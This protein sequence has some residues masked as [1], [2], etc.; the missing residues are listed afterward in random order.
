MF[1]N[2]RYIIK[3]VP[4]I[5]RFL[6]VKGLKCDLPNQQI[7]SQCYSKRKS[8]D[9]EIID[10]NIDEMMYKDQ[11]FAANFN[12]KP[13]PEIINATDLKDAVTTEIDFDFRTNN[14][15]ETRGIFADGCKTLPGG[16]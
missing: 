12:Y 11:E 6:Q 3:T 4:R 14:S 5:T 2:T 16:K 15:L 1:S 13:P 10:V 9:I 7:P 8:K